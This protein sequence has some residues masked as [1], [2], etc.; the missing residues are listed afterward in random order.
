MKNLALLTLLAVMLAGCAQN[1]NLASRPA[2]LSAPVILNSMKKVADWQLTNASPSDAH[3]QGN[4]W[5]Y[6]AFYV[7]VMALDG[8]AKTPKYHDA[9]VA[10]GKKFDWQPGPKA[11]HADDQC[12]EE[13]AADRADPADDDHHQHGDDDV[14]AHA[15]LHHE[16]AG[17]WRAQAR[18]AQ[19]QGDI[20]H[21]LELENE[22]IAII[23]GSMKQGKAGAQAL[24]SLLRDRAGI[25]AAAG[26][27]QDAEK[28][29]RHALALVQAGMRPGDVSAANGRAQLALAR[30]LSTEGKSEEARGFAT[31]ALHQLKESVGPDHPDTRGAAELSGIAAGPTG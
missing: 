16:G 22:G 1:R 12:A 5:T 19:Q 4:S 27:L 25:E 14:V 18:I 23:E 13:R 3:Y 31:E 20:G 26:Q 29:A 24:P 9:M 30:I 6:G 2:E 8:I 10:V 28:D 15:R 21:A 17:M 11:Y 7:G